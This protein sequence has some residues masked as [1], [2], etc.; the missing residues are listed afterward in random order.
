MVTQPSRLDSDSSV[1]CA[2]STSVGS[3]GFAS[4]R[5]MKMSTLFAYPDG[6]GASGPPVTTAAAIGPATDAFVSRT[7]TVPIPA[8]V[9]SLHAAT[10]RSVA[11]ENAIAMTRSDLTI[12]SSFV[13]ETQ[14]RRRFAS[15]RRHGVNDWAAH[16]VAQ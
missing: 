14:E 5:T 6:I 7:F 4:M 16:A 2:A 10:P 13:S 15:P 8:P 9:E 1:A 11:A 12:H 3:F